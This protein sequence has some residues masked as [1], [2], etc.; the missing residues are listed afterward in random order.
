MLIN[1]R[2][3]S[4]ELSILSC[5]S[6]R[7]SLSEKEKQYYTALEK[8][9]KGEQQFD[10]YLETSLEEWFVISD[11]MLEHNNSFFQI[12]SLGIT[13]ETLYLFDVK[14]YDGDFI[15]ENDRWKSVTGIELKNPLH[16]LTRC[17]TL[18]RR[19]LLERGIHFTIKSFLIFINPHFTLYQAPFNPSIIFPTQLTQFLKRLQKETTNLDKRHNNL[20]ELLVSANQKNYPNSSIHKYSYKQLPKGL[21]C[22]SCG[23]LLTKISQVEQKRNFICSICYCK[24]RIEKAVL[25]SVDDLHLL[26]PERKITAV[27]VYE[28][29]GKL[30][31]KKRIYR[32][33]I[34]NFKRV[35][36]GKY[37]SYKRI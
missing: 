32:I 4:T 13:Q 8:G 5:L 11:L 10:E 14:N 2:K 21:I 28:W 7:N 36:K 15:I 27:E 20:A 31:S 16:Q 35:G 9:F 12:D 19:F 25:R 37:S 29:C 6:T 26:F 17:E 34:K 18:L 24:E 30:L 22:P 3:E 1:P 33:L 23:S